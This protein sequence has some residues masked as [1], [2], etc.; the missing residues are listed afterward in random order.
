[1]S[2]SEQSLCRIKYVSRLH[3]ITSETNYNA[4]KT[5]CRDA[6]VIQFGQTKSLSKCRIDV[7]RLIIQNRTRARPTAACAIDNNMQ[8]NII[9]LSFNSCNWN[10]M[11]LVWSHDGTQTI[12]SKRTSSENAIVTIMIISLI[13]Y[14]C[15]TSQSL[16]F[17]IWF[18]RYRG[19]WICIG[20]HDVFIQTNRV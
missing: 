5:D 4:A 7:L 16:H 11:T 12:F 10:A 18:L 2:A 13:I 15:M 20:I 17:F 8:N 3:R 19:G 9:L 6:T 14:L 1:M